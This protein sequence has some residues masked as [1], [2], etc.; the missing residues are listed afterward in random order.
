MKKSPSTSLLAASLLALSLSGFAQT[1][2]YQPTNLAGAG[3][4]YIVPDTFIWY[5]YTN[6]VTVGPVNIGD[7][8]GNNGNWEPYC[9]ILGDSHFLFGFCS[10]ALDGSATPSSTPSDSNPT[11]LGRQQY[12]VAV[13]PVNGGAP[14]VASA[15]YDDYGHPFTN[16]IT[17]RQNGNPFHVTGDKR[18]GGTNYMVGGEASPNEW[19]G[20]SGSFPNATNFF[21]SDQRWDHPVWASKGLAATTGQNSPTGDNANRYAIAQNFGIDPNNLAHGPYELGKT[22]DVT[23][24]SQTNF[25]G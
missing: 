24:S 2:V 22:L 10:Y 21:D 12:Y 16:E 19:R 17:V 14:K 11:P 15:F 6:H 8:L 5:G 20:V 4:S 23:L 9:G 7:Q 3:L 25:L 1:Y 13:V 18:Y